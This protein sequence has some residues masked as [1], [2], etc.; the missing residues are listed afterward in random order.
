MKRLFIIPVLLICM[1]GASSNNVQAPIE[2]KWKTANNSIGV[3][4]QSTPISTKVDSVNK[5]AIELN[6]LIRMR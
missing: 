4:P 1:T 6:H 3:V 2:D 5:V